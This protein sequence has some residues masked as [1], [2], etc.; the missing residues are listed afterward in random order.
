M[1]DELKELF[2][3]AKDLPTEE[4]TR[5]EEG[6][7]DAVVHAVEFTESKSKNLM[8]KWEFIVTEGPKKGAHEWKYNV[9]NK[10]EA[11]KRLVTELGK[12]GI[13]TT[14]IEKMQEQLGDV[15][16]VPVKMTIKMSENKNNPAEPYRNVSVNP[17]S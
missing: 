15:L 2:D 10:P 6:T 4:F 8:F 17:C 12:F 3:A 7:Y 14:S 5:L 1:M 11:M 13:D 9:L 16:D